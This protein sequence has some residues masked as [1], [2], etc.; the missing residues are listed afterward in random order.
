MWWESWG[1]LK[2]EERKIIV[3]DLSLASRFRRVWPVSANCVCFRFG[4]YVTQGHDSCPRKT[5]H[6]RGLLRFRFDSAAKFQ[7]KRPLM[8]VIISSNNMSRFE[9]LECA[10]YWPSDDLKSWNLTW[11]RNVVS[12]RRWLNW[13]V[14][15]QSSIWRL[16]VS[17]FESLSAT[18]SLRR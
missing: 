14:N 18:N 1:G 16:H 2:K 11:N 17:E 12:W 10:G 5:E 13:P 3:K 8:V 6:I 7:L 15:W 9:I 4:S